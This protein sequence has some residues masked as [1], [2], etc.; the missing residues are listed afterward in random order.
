MVWLGRR[1]DRSMGRIPVGVVER[2]VDGYIGTCCEAGTSSF[3]RTVEEAFANLREATWRQLE[4]QGVN[5]SAADADD[6]LGNQRL[7]A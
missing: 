7:A 1:E 5:G 6:R 4:Q 3:G 2:A